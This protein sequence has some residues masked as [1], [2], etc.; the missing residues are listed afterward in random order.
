MP[1]PRAPDA[2]ASSPRIVASEPPT[3]G[4]DGHLADYRANLLGFLLALARGHGPVATYRLRDW[5]QY[6]LTDPALVAEPLLKCPRAYVKNRFVWKHNRRFLGEGLLTSEGEVWRRKRLVQAKAFQPQQLA[7]YA[8]VMTACAETAAGSWIDGDVRPMHREM[9]LLT[10]R[11]V[12]RTLLGF[13]DADADAGIDARIV[14]AMDTILRELPLR[15]T[16]RVHYPDWIPTAANRRWNAALA[17]LDRTVYGFIDRARQR[18]ATTAGNAADTTGSLLA[19]LLAARD[20][21]GRPPTRRAL[22]DDVVTQFFAG[23][24]T[25]AAGLSWTLWL[26]S[27]HPEAM[28]RL[29]GEVDAVIGTGPVRLEALPKLDWAARVVRESHR[30]YPPVYLIG[31]T[32][33]DDHAID[34][35]PIERGSV[36]QISS[37]VLHRDPARYPDPE[38]F[39]PERWTPDFD[40][41]LPRFGYL[42]FGGGP[43]TCIGERYAIMESLIV[44]ATIVRDWHFEYAGREPPRPQVSLTLKPGGGVPLRLHRRRP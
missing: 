6:L 40:A 11:I 20:D 36:V 13:D 43:R 44:L 41:H 24:E 17:E 38:A 23:H 27:Q 32:P 39:R 18:A 9:M 30:L 19:I 3:R 42:P 34:G 25:T 15:T 1:D 29:V 26:L 2:A 28:A 33:L 8:Q 14:G 4:P 7:R 21:R 12:A 35:C 10:A 16:R 22:R 5:R 37:W 31:R